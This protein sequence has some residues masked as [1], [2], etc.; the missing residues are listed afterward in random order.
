MTTHL[1]QVNDSTGIE[2]FNQYQPALREAGK[3]DRRNFT[4]AIKAFNEYVDS[5]GEGA[6]R[7]D[8]A[9]SN[10]TRTVYSAFGLNKT[11]REALAGGEAYDR[12]LFTVTELRYLQMAESTAAEIIWEGMA[13]KASRRSIKAKVKEECGRIASSFRRHASGYFKGGQ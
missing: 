7:P 2:R 8:L 9:Y 11:Q 13:A 1:M 3:I 4:D 12:G 5:E 6:S 10:F